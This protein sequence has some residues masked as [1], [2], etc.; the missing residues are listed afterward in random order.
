MLWSR[1]INTHAKIG[2]NIPA[3]QHMEHLN[4]VVKQAIKNLG[5]NKTEVGLTRVG[6]AIANIVPVIEKFYQLHT[7]QN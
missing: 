1:F 3:D 2:K 7:I 5:V 4:K 6:K